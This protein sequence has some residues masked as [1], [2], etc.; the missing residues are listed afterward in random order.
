MF[1]GPK[2][3]S[4]QDLVA[5]HGQLVSQEAEG[6]GSYRHSVGAVTSGDPQHPYANIAAVRF[7]IEVA[8]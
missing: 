3:N 6:D 1:D 8:A 5:G 4:L 7:T 2:P